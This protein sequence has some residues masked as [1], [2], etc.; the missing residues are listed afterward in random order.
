MNSWHEAIMVSLGLLNIIYSA[1]VVA[2]SCKVYLQALLV[3]KVAVDEEYCECEEE[4]QSREHV[5]HLI[6]L[7]DLSHELS[8]GVSEVL[9]AH[10]RVA[11][12]Q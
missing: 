12:H 11:R 4:N 7:L 5:P 10:L 3:A 1:L 8:R 2:L 6:Q 9:D